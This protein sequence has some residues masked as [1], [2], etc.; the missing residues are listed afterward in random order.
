MS[1]NEIL[2]EIRVPIAG[3]R[4]AAPH[5]PSCRI[6]LPVTWSSAR[7]VDHAPGLRHL[8]LGTDCHRRL[9]Q[10][11]DP[12]HRNRNGTARQS[13]D[14]AD[15]RRRRGQS[16]RRDRPGWKISYASAEYK[17]HVATVLRAQGDR[18]GGRTRGKKLRTVFVIVTRVR[19]QTRSIYSAIR[20]HEARTRARSY[21]R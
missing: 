17:R 3:R 5:T 19:K 8:R 4:N 11:S 21:T 2:T 1:A 15:H 20:S 18:G 6:R 9:G 7:R 14:Y 13:P 16:R 12:R 10:R